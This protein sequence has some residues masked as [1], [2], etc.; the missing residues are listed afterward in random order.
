[1]TR[2]DLASDAVGY[3]GYTG[4]TGAV[5]AAVHRAPRFD[6]MSDDPAMAMCAFRRQRMNRAFETVES[7]R[8][9]RPDDL[10]GLVVIVPAYVTLRHVGPP[11][12]I[13]FLDLSS[14]CNRC[15][16]SGMAA[17]LEQSAARYCYEA[18]AKTGRRQNLGTFQ[19]RAAPEQ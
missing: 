15:A 8:P 17:K 5:G 14:G 6:P 3:A 4:F 10:K 19:T 9:S 2:P 1:M 11:V 16:D 18:G 7:V 12:H 13:P